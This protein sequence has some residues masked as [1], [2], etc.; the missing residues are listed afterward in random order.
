[1]QLHNFQLETMVPTVTHYRVFDPE[2]L[3]VSH[4]FRLYAGGIFQFEES[5][6]KVR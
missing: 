4:G 6:I 1:M 2:A 5:E 3:L